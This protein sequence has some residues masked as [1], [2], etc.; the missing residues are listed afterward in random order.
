ME[1]LRD[2]EF[3]E[4]YCDHGLRA[5]VSKANS[6]GKEAY[7]LDM[8]VRPNDPIITTTVTYA[9]LREL[10]KKTKL[11]HNRIVRIDSENEVEI[12]KGLG[13]KVDNNPNSIT[14]EEMDLGLKN[15]SREFAERLLKVTDVNVIRLVADE[16]AIL[17]AIG[18]VTVSEI[19]KLVI[20]A[21]QEE[22]NKGKEES[23]ITLDHLHFPTPRV[24]EVEK[25]VEVEKI[26]EVEKVVEKIVEVEVEKKE[27]PKKK[28]TTK[29]TTTKKK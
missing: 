9:D 10:A 27:A 3:L 12:L 2:E 13:I 6:G 26:V 25:V 29:K 17:D 16:Y 21:R 7:E 22:L 28:T 4:I 14:R 20:R 8:R 11:L 5:M 23:S 15:C 24:I 19:M 1:R 18:E